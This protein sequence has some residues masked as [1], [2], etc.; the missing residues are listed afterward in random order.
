M[1]AL[2]VGLE[3]PIN[4]VSMDGE[5]A[6]VSECSADRPNSAGEEQTASGHAKPAAQN[7]SHAAWPDH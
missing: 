5:P 7:V 1:D 6:L 3:K 4:V 2:C